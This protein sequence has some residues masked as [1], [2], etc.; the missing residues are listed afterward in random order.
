MTEESQI[1]KS[2]APAIIQTTVIT[3]IGVIL[4]LLV[5]SALTVIGSFISYD[6]SSLGNFVRL[7]VVLLVAL[8]ILSVH[9]NVQKMKYSMSSAGITTSTGNIVGKKHL[10]IYN[11]AIITSIELD[12]PALND[13]FHYD[14][15]NL[16]IDMLEN[17]E[18]PKAIVANICSKL[19]VNS[20]RLT[21]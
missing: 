7:L 11:L 1:A 15:I 18:R 3:V 5:S 9:T 4:F 21:T 14:N 12:Q 16:N 19:R 20:K 2:P 17:I 8:A 10:Q 13:K 6:A